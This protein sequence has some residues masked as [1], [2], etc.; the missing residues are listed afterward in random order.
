[1]SLMQSFKRSGALGALLLAAIAGNAS[2]TEIIGDF[3]DPSRAQGWT[4]ASEL[5]WLASPD[6]EVAPP[7][8]DGSG[9]LSMMAFSRSDQFSYATAVT[10]L[11]TRQ[12]IRIRYE[13]L[14]YSTRN[15]NGAAAGFHLIDASAGPEL[16]LQD[17][18]YACASSTLMVTFSHESV[19]YDACNGPYDF[20]NKFNRVVVRAD[21]HVV[22]KEEAPMWLTCGN[23]DWWSGTRLPERDC[24]S[25]ED[26]IAKGFVRSVDALVTPDPL[27]EGY[28]LDLSID[29]QP[30]YS[31]LVIARPLP[32]MVRFGLWGDH[33]GRP[34]HF[35]RNVHVQHEPLAQR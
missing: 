8:M 34:H 19:Y 21:N 27:G 11:D 7:T 1:M 2:A 29:G 30:V 5:T 35:V 3:T 24:T 17:K 22:A 9:W 18:A 32:P 28:T 23:Y 31:Q 14:S 20:W 16:H 25:R 12:P 33:K 15:I 13:F 26:A 4:L 6:T 10:P